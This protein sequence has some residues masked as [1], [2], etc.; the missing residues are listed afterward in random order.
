MMDNDFL[1][2]IIMTKAFTKHC[3]TTC[4][5]ENCAK[6]L[7]EEFQENP[8]TIKVVRKKKK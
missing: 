8:E 3:T 2:L 5:S 4:T 1:K 7:A 6:C